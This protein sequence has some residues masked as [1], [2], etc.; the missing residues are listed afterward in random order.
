MRKPQASLDEEATGER[1]TGANPL[2][3]RAMRRS[4]KGPTPQQPPT[5]DA[6]A[7]TNWREYPATSSIEGG[8]ASGTPAFG[9][10][11]NGK[12]VDFAISSQIGRR[13]RNPKEQFAP[14]I[15]TPIDSRA[16]AAAAGLSPLR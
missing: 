12:V 9:F 11:A 15:S 8:D 14:T 6:P 1:R 7:S 13:D 2:T 3:A 4:I 16:R 10:I 5:K